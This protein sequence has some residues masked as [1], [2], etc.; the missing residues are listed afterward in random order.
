MKIINNKRDFVLMRMNSCMG[1]PLLML[2]VSVSQITNQSQHSHKK[3]GDNHK[4]RERP[5][6]LAQKGDRERDKSSG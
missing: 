6:Q 1:K 3:E 5:G 4:G 2:N